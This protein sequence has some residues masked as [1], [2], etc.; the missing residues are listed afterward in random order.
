MI[1]DNVII[2]LES[3]LVMQGLKESLVMVIIERLKF[4]HY[5]KYMPE[6]VVFLDKSCPGGSP[7]CNDNGQCDHTTGLCICN[8][9]NQESDCSAGNSYNL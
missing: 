4:Y 2:Q 1:M 6:L 5:E 3:V 7:P 9:G 8:E